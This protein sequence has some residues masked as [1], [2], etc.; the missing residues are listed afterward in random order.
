MRETLKQ[1]DLVTL[2]AV[3]DSYVVPE[4]P[5]LSPA[6]QMAP[7]YTVNPKDLRVWL[8]DQGVVLAYGD[9]R[10]LK[11]QRAWEDPSRVQ[12]QA[13]R[14]RDIR[15]R[16]DGTERN[17]RVAEATK[18]S[19]DRYRQ[20]DEA[21]R[22]RCQ[23]I[24]DGWTPEARERLGEQSTVWMREHFSDP[25]NRAEQSARQFRFWEGKDKQERRAIV[26]DRGGFRKGRIALPTV[27]EVLVRDAFPDL[28]EYT[29]DNLWLR[30][31]NRAKSPDFVVRPGDPICRVVEVFGNYWHT[32]DEEPVLIAD[33]AA[34]GI[35][36]LVVWEDDIHNHWA[37][38]RQRIQSFCTSNITGNLADHGLNDGPTAE[39]SA[40]ANPV[41]SADP[42]GDST[43]GN[44]ERSPDGNVRER[45]T[46]EARGYRGADP[47]PHAGNGSLARGDA[48]E[49]AR[50]A[51]P[52]R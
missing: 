51:P 45:V 23:T 17:R 35:E 47:H 29:G 12:A 41:N 26:F 27:P 24:S 22:S 3:Y 46:T 21:Y 2:Q 37:S 5:K 34:A 4:R 36:C 52:G 7:D 30:L 43:Q 44:A 48:R 38:V 11:I 33:Y 9:D 15:S 19:W 31:P 10:A 42:T 20:D 25:Q 16:E 28:L 32:R 39:Q 6:K 13:E 50:G 18:R 14:L 40:V 8:A 1:M 49:R